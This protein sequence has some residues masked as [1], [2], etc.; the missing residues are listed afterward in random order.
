MGKAIVQEQEGHRL[1]GEFLSAKGI[2]KRFGA[3]VVLEN[4][5]FSM[6]DGDAVG[7]VGPNGAGKT[8][9]LS[10][11][12]GAF[13]L[14]AGTITFNGRNV[15][16]L[17]AADRC[18]SGLVRT[19]QI[20][21]PFSGMTTFENV[22][23]AASH[24]K[25]SNRD[26]AYERAVDSL[27]LCGMLSV[28]NRRA[29]TLGLL[30]RKRLEL[31]RALATGPRLLLLD[32]IGGGLTDGEASELVGT[33]LELRRRGIGIVW[34]EHIVHILLQVVERLICMDAGKI[35]A[36]GDPKAVMSDAEVVRAYLGG[37]PA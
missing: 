24:G 7:I 23:V 15:T 34:I 16:A 37:A 33:I 14:N 11:L 19:H 1:G 25:T 36:D 28:A 29:D 3:L 5:D 17:T 10:A 35:I 21:K 4:L 9:L 26:E 18:R 22:F 32:E 2:H 27:Q 8:T 31:A 12:A 6:G 20:P 30:D 13:P